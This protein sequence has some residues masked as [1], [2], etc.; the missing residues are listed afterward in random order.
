LVL[1]Y[2]ADGIDTDA[3]D[4]SPDMLAV[5]RR[6][7]AEQ[8]V[9]VDARLFQQS[10][11]TL[12]LPRRYRTIVV[13]SS[14]FQL[15]ADLADARRALQRFADHL[16]PS[17]TLVMSLMLLWTKEPPA[18]VFTTEWSGWQEATRASDGAVFRR[19]TR[20]TYDMVAQLESTE[21]EYERVQDGRTVARQAQARSPATRWYTQE[22]AV[23]LLRD[24]G[25]VDVRLTS[26]FTR[27]P[28]KPEDPLFCAIAV[29]P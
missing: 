17:G 3:V 2:R 8:G 25:Y 10:M 12:D 4:V 21:D 18:P 23:A 5:V 14:S 24:A 27:Q 7:A 22:Q 6:K 16:E 29:R 26:G 19:R 28:A 20:S 11:E 1:T 15:L 13:S 9:D